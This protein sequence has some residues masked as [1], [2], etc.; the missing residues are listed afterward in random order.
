MQLYAPRLTTK[1]S[2][3][4][5]LSFSP[6]LSDHSTIQKLPPLLFSPLDFSKQATR[7]RVFTSQPPRN[8]AQPCETATS[9]HIV[10]RALPHPLHEIFQLRVPKQSLR[11]GARSGG[12]VRVSRYLSSHGKDFDSLWLLRRRLARLI[13]GIATTAIDDRAGASCSTLR[14]HVGVR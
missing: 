9:K 4:A 14:P 7:Q 5:Y 8:Q 2:H 10:A 12:S 3:T 1:D 11:R 13:I 6:S